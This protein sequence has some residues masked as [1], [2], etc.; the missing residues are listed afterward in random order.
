MLPRIVRQAHFP[1]KG[2][3]RALSFLKSHK[4]FCFLRYLYKQNAKKEECGV[5]D[6]FAQLYQ[7]LLAWIEP[8]P[9]RLRRGWEAVASGLSG[10]DPPEPISTQL[11]FSQNYG[12]PGSEAEPPKLIS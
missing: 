2:P 3:R 12:I 5:E 8:D 4:P 1:G 6:D 9:A 11:H 7:R 10:A